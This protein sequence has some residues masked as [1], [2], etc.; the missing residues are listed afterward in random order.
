[1]SCSDPISNALIS[2]KNCERV[3]KKECTL[4]PASKLLGNVLEVMKQKKYIEGY[5]Y[6]EDRKSGVFRVE[7]AGKINECR[8]VRPRF[9]VKKDEFEKFEKRYLP[10]KDIGV[11]IVS[12]SQGVFS[13]QKAAE[14]GI[15]GRILA[16][17]Y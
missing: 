15:G 12:T 6:I 11:L 10:A 3:A 8:A 2:I 5:K 9:T 7:L 13:H 4:K 17:V 14:K 16:Y 1:M